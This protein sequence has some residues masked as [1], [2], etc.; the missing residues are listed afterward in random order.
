MGN[1]KMKNTSD[2]LRNYVSDLMVLC[3]ND[4]NCM[5]ILYK[6]GLL[7]MSDVKISKPQQRMSRSVKDRFSEIDHVLSVIAAHNGLQFKY[8]DK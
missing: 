3:R 2:L 7:L 8:L 5:D 1:I 4:E 6:I